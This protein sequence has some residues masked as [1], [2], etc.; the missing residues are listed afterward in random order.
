MS[1]A[2]SKASKP[3]QAQTSKA[4]SAHAKKPH[5]PTPAERALIESFYRTA[6]RET[7]AP[8]MKVEQGKTGARI[9]S[10]HPDPTTFHAPSI[11]R[12]L[13][14]FFAR[15]EFSCQLIPGLSTTTVV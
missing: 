9:D 7:P 15:D 10:R 12:A 11:V 5:I 2:N 8:N 1:A 6:E 3:D 4:D 13:E 14:S